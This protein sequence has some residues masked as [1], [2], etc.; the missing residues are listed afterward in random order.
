M[1]SSG[2]EESVAPALFASCPFI[3]ACE[4][5]GD[6]LFISDSFEPA[7]RPKACLRQDQFTHERP[8][9]GEAS[10]GLM[11]PSCVSLSLLQP[12]NSSYAATAKVKAV[13]APATLIAALS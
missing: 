10:M 11:C 4:A 2:S 6:D 8:A 7:R 12:A 1:S 3:A 9:F 13:F 5:D